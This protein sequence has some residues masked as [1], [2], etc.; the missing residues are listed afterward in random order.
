M[1]MR[2]RFVLLAGLLI[3]SLAANAATRNGT[4]RIKI[5]DSETHSVILDNS[6]VPK[7]C[8]GLNYDAYCNS[9]QTMQT[10][11]TLL[12]QVGNGTPFRIA[13][14][15]DAKWSRC[16]SLTTGESFD[17]RRVKHGIVVYYLDDGGRPRRQLYA[18]LSSDPG[19]STVS[20]IA[21]PN[22]QVS[23][24]EQEVQPGTLSK[25]PLQQTVRCSFGSVP[26]GA[27]V[28]VD[29]QYVGGTPSVLP[30]STGAHNVVLS[31][32]GYVP[33]TR[34]LTVLP[35]SELTVNAVMEKTE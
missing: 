15:V 17:A 1:M 25:K 2:T 12:A 18:F 8:D 21:S 29:G 34:E 13:C 30:L 14:S 28:T 26:L 9:S 35:G 32:P 4:V 11:N 33:W 23:A 24:A 22:Q 5:L 19:N 16:A 6:G 31:M 10:T 3:S 20:A 27:E 7:N